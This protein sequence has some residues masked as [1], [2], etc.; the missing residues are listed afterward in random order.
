MLVY[1]NVLGYILHILI[2]RQLGPELYGEFMVAYSFMLSIGFLSSVYPSI[3]IKSVIVSKSFRYDILRFIRILSIISGFFMLLVA[4]VISKPISEFLKVEQKFIVI[5]G[6]VWLFVFISSVEKGFLQAKE[7]FGVYSIINSMEL[8]IRFL[9][10]IVLLYAGYGISGLISSNLISIALITLILYVINGNIKGNISKID[11]RESIS[12]V[13]TA[14]PSGVF[15]YADDLFIRRV[16]DP[17][18]AGVYAS[19]SIVGKAFVW[20]CIT[21]FSVFFVKIIKDIHK[22]KIILAKYITFVVIATTFVEIGVISFGRHIFSYMFGESF[23]NSAEFLALYLPATLPMIISVAIF[24][25]NIGIQKLT[26]IIY[27]HLTTYLVGFVIL[28]FDNPYI[29]LLYIFLVN[30]IFTLIYVYML[31]IVKKA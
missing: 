6:F 13:L 16:F 15:I 28:N 21:I 26:K 18:T 25:T 27:I 12:L 14:F 4:V 17:S 29:Y 9:I 3:T 20:F 7:K 10:A 8:T 22:Y 19:A 31:F 30:M 5:I 23:K 24:S 2:A 11:F 1:I